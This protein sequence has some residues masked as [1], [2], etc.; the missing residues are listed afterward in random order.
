MTQLTHQL[1]Q[2]GQ[3]KTMTHLTHDASRQPLWV[4]HLTHHALAHQVYISHCLYKLT[5]D[6]LTALCIHVCMLICRLAY[7]LRGGGRAGGKGPAATMGSLTI[8][9]F[10]NIVQTIRLQAKF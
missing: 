1:G 3:Q 5:A 9:N 7:V 10:F 6:W 8:F 2:L 4:R